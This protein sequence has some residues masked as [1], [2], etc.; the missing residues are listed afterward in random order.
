MTR[1]DRGAS[2][3]DD[4]ARAL[5]EG[6]LSRRRALK[7][8][9]G[10]AIAALIPS[11]ALAQQQKVT[12]CHKAGTPDEE[13]KE[14]SPSAVDNHLRH[15]DQLGRCSP[16]PDG[17]VLLDNGTC[18]K[19]CTSGVDCPPCSEQCSLASSLDLYCTEGTVTRRQG[20]PNGD[21]DCPEGQ[22][23]QFGLGDP[24]LCAVAC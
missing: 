22:F 15:G 14:I 9:A 7:L 19:P 11:R 8:F 1:E 16:C 17:R 3:F 24:D 10:G 13:T 23:C 5:A 20:C 4:L 21:I 6:S 12:I 18:A 2:S